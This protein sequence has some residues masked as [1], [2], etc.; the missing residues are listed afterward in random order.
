[1][2]GKGIKKEQPEKIL[3]LLFYN[4][5]EFYKI[6]SR[7]QRQRN[8]IAGKEYMKVLTLN[9]H[10]WLEEKTLE[11]IKEVAQVIAREDFDVISLQEVNQLVTAKEV[12]ENCLGKYYQALDQEVRIK[13]DNYVW[14]LV[15]ALNEL[16]CSYYWTWAYSHLGYERFDEGVALL[17]K[18]SFSAEP[19]VVSACKDPNDY[20]RRVIIQA[21]IVTERGQLQ[22]WSVHYS[23]W[24]KEEREDGFQREWRR[25]LEV[26]DH[27]VGPSLLLGDCN[28]PTHRRGESYDLLL[29]SRLKDSYYLAK[30]KRGKV[31]T[32]S[33][34]AG[35]A[36]ETPPQRIDHVF[37]TSPFQVEDY[38]V[39]FD[40]KEESVVSDHYGV[41]VSLRLE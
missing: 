28:A 8:Q 4:E 18:T 1:M 25:T 33:G 5:N 10:A 20:H 6:G 21:E 36:Q 27:F 19:I 7:G 31:T 22:V 34:I 38:R 30:K 41:S 32:L 35:W 9:T 2:R 26:S 11:K 15:Q 16:R 12:D 24:S 14:L 23:W 3:R 39:M 13:E 29:K 17:S 40:G 37:V